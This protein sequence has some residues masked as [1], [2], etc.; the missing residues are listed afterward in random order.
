MAAKKKVQ[1]P[2]KIKKVTTLKKGSGIGAQDIL[3]G[4]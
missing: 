3:I 2:K 1:K 4:L